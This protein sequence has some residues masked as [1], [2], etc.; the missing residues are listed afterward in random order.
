MEHFTDY[1]VITLAACKSFKI[2]I[3]D[4]TS[5]SY[6]DGCAVLKADQLLLL[7]P[8]PCRQTCCSCFLVGPV[9]REVC[10]SCRCYYCTHR[11]CCCCE[12]RKEGKYQ[13]RSVIL[14]K[15]D[16]WSGIDIEVRDWEQAWVDASRGSVAYKTADRDGRK[17]NL[18]AEG[19]LLVG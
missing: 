5:R 1:W 11:L 15:A 3:V 14:T 9:F 16:I 17:A 10:R 19:C 13:G 6:K 8:C 7:L 12:S 18:T 4:L 2:L